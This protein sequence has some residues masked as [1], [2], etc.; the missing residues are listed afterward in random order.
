MH[1]A[2]DTK[3]PVPPAPTQSSLVPVLR[4]L[5]HEL[6]QPLSGIE[7]IAYYLD[8][9]LGDAQP[10]IAQHCQRLRCMVQQANWILNDAFL[11]VCLHDAPLAPFPLRTF[12][13]ALG[14]QLVHQEEC[15]LELH[16]TPS[17]PS[18]SA[19]LPAAR[20]FEH[21]LAFFRDVALAFDPICV[22]ATLEA[23]FVR[24]T[25]QSEITIDA[26]E[27]RR[28]L[29]ALAQGSGVHAFF[30]ACGATLDSTVADGAL[31]LSMRFAAA[32]NQF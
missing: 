20:L 27:I 5:S 8:M 21:L 23:G 13:T 2:L 22:S 26:S 12:F 7:S 9:V 15:T 25:I 6:R 17:I 4:H 1:P 28:L 19:P 10:E 29:A 16:F 31:T 32:P 11:A 24:L 3:V 30:Q 14:A 18:I